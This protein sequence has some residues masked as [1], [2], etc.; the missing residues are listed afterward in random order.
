VN[1]RKHALEK[2]AL[3][4]CY[5]V[6][7]EQDV[8]EVFLNVYFSFLPKL[9]LSHTSLKVVRL[10]SYFTKDKH[11]SCKDSTLSQQLMYV[12]RTNDT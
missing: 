2:S 10:Q 3:A 11:I 1:H 6:N 7:D 4:F 8:K 5:Q 12:S 9:P